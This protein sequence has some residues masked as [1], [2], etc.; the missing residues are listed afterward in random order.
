MSCPKTQRNDLGQGC[1]ACRD[2]R[3]K[4]SEEAL[5]FFVKRSPLARQFAVENGNYYI[6]GIQ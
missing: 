3:D 5:N 4:P 6:D 2:V 1:W